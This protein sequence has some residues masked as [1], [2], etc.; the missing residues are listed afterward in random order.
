M[1]PL[2]VEPRSPRPQRGILTT[3]LWRLSALDEQTDT[4]LFSQIGCCL[5]SETLQPVFT[6]SNVLEVGLVISSDFGNI[7]SISL[8]ESH[9][10]PWRPGPDPSGVIFILFL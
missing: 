7:S 10:G 6:G 4:G 8:L 3:K 9:V 2:G 5:Q 1:T